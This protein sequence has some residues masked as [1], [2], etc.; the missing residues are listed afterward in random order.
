MEQ[1]DKAIET[2]ISS[3]SLSQ[4]INELNKIVSCI[5]GHNESFCVDD[6]SDKD[7]LEINDEYLSQL[8][9]YLFPRRYGWKDTDCNVSKEANQHKLAA[10]INEQLDEIIEW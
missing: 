7:K 4:E 2:L 10:K 6:L 1:L 5:S 8:I 3:Q 9:E